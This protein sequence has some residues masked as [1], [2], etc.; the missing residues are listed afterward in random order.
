[1]LL[2]PLAAVPPPV[3]G[4]DLRRVDDAAG[5]RTFNDV[6]ADAFGLDRA[7]LAVLDDPRMLEFP[8]FGFH[9]AFLQASPDGLPLY[10]RM[11]FQHAMEMQ[12]WSLA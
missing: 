11:R 10:E 1:M 3:A 2:V 8:G 6:C 4:L 7:I 5:L 12:T 9:L